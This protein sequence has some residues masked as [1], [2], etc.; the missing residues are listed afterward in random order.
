MRRL[1]HIVS[2]DGLRVDLENVDVVKKF[3]A[4]NYQTEVDYFL[5]LASYYRCYVCNFAATL[6]LLINVIELSSVFSR[7]EEAQDVFE[8]LKACLASTSILDFRCLQQPLILYADAKHFAM[9]AVFALL[10]DG[11]MRAI[12]YA[13]MALSKLQ[14]KHST[15]RGELRAIVTFRRH[16]RQYVLGQKLT[17]VTDH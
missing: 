6:R 5:E 15:S 14:I 17:V 7:S 16:F 8:Y 12:C 11:L 1:S 13:S 9:R 3:P 4:P 10:Q 2:K